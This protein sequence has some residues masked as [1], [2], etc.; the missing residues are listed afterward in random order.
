[1]RNEL[2]EIETCCR[3]IIKET[4][5]LLLWEW[6][7]YISAFLSTFS[8]G[9][10]EQIETICDKYFMSRWDRSCMPKIPPAVMSIAE[11]LGGLRSAQ[12]L[13]VTR[14]DQFVMAF[15][16][17]WPWGDGQRISLRIG[18]YTHR[19]PEHAREEFLKEFSGWFKAPV[20]MS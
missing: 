1:M 18:L 13:L 15:G 3:G 11:T 5:E 20:D 6:D 4:G 10:S 16:A 7:D 12:R 9:Q 14:P 19:V 2:A 17:W 8:I